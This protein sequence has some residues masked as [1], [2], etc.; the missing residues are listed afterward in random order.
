MIKME[1]SFGAIQKNPLPI[2]LTFWEKL[3]Q[4]TQLSFHRQS[5]SKE[6]LGWP[7][8]GKG[9]VM[10]RENDNVLIYNEKGIWFNKLGDQVHFTNVFRWRLDRQAG[11]ISLEHLRQGADRPVFLFHLVPTHIHS[12]SCVDLH[13][14]GEDA[15]SSQIHLVS[16]GLCLNWRVIGPKKNQEIDYYYS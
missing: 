12:L 6:E 1:L 13:L 16:T 8:K 3:R 7:E 14:C 4:V 9:Q 11:A 10:S 5:I 15:Y 2:L